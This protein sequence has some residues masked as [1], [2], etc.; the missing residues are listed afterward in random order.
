MGRNLLR[1]TMTER[2]ILSFVRH[3]FI[4][5]LYYAFQT[6]RQL[7]LILQFC[8]GGNLQ[9]LI[10]RESGLNEPVARLFTAEI[11]LAL[12]HLHERR[13]VFRDLKPGNIVH[14]DR[15]H[16]MLTDF[17]L[18]KEG[19]AGFRG[20]RSFCGS[21]AYLA[22]EIVRRQ[23]HGHAVDI[24]G[25]GVLL[26]EML[27]GLPPYYTDDRETL[28]RNIESARLRVPAHVSPSASS[29]IQALMERNPA[30]R[31][32]A[33]CS[34]SVRRHVFFDGLDFDKVLR[35]EIPVPALVAPR[36]LPGYVVP[37]VTPQSPFDKGKGS[38]QKP[39]RGHEVAGWE[40]AS[41]ST[42]TGS[43]SG[44][45]GKVHISKENQPPIIFESV[46][47]K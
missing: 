41:P 11:L 43:L 1:Y 26:Y 15:G 12:E 32:G 5:S 36:A 7:V 33:N 17:G 25:L 10:S 39:W 14:D 35:R 34:S 46:I 22:P 24:Y 6:P 4:V 37:P 40:F 45:R 8:S 23:E 44:M 28:F 9:R 3:P 13:I 47:K 20:A 29:L 19:V 21:V 16:A 27:V 18:S 42:R 38:S 2:N 31:L 30:Q